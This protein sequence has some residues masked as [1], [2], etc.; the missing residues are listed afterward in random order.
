MSEVPPL[1]GDQVASVSGVSAS[2][3]ATCGTLRDQV[4]LHLG[5]TEEIRDVSADME[6]QVLSAQSRIENLTNCSAE[7]AAIAET[8]SEIAGQTKLLALNASIESARAGEAGRGFAVVA[9][10]VGELAARAN[11]STLRI[12]AM[13]AEI[14]SDTMVA[15]EMMS[16]LVKAVSGNIKESVSGLVD[17]LQGTAEEV[18]LIAVEALSLAAQTDEFYE[19]Y[20]EAALSVE[21]G[22]AVDTMKSAVGEVESK[23][24][25]AI[26]AGLITMAELFDERYEPIPDT[27]PVKY[28][29]KFDELT[30]RILPAIQEPLLTG[31]NN[32]VIAACID[33]KGYIPTHNRFCSQPPSGNYQQDLVQS[34]SKRIFDDDAGLRAATNRKPFLIQTSKRDTGQLIH[35]IA[36]PIFVEG[37]RWGNLRCGLEVTDLHHGSTNGQSE[38]DGAKIRP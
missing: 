31:P 13:A 20:G 37:R 36:V 14:D 4:D 15:S 27:D 34:R 19:I 17:G 10:E 30:D 2:L 22:A 18:D 11:E 23:F 38:D 33:R 21:L 9:T 16:G 7:I 6:G 1:V 12:S 26:A 32:F 24:A 28:R 5:L 3:S 35:D 29:T 25:D 8:I